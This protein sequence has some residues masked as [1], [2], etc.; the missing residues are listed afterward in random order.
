MNLREIYEDSKRLISIA[1]KD[2]QMSKQSF[3]PV[4]ESP[5]VFDDRFLTEWMTRMYL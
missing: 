2:L 4:L 1:F 3:V 5:E